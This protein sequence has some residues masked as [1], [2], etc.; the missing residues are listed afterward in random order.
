MILNYVID[1]VYNESFGRIFVKVLTDFDVEEQRAI[2]LYWRLIGDNKI[3]FMIVG[4]CS[5]LPCSS[6][7]RCPR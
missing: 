6:M 3:F 7:W 4:F 5:C 2:D 1:G